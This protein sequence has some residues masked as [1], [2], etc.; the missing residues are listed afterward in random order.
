MNTMRRR[1]GCVCVKSSVLVDFFFFFTRINTVTPA[2]C[3]KNK[4]IKILF[5][6]F[7]RV[8]K[9]TEHVQPPAALIF[10]REKEKRLP[11][12]FDMNKPTDVF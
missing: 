5:F 7:P 8:T 2:S 10:G 1:R 6:L 12:D 11:I 4:K 3:R 9:A